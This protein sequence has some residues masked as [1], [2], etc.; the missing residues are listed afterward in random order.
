MKRTSLLWI[1]LVIFAFGCK[2]EKAF[3]PKVIIAGN[4]SNSEAKEIKVY[5]D[6]EIANTKLEEDGSF[7]VSFDADKF[8]NYMLTAGR[9]RLN[10]FLSPGDSLYITGDAAKFGESIVFSGDHE[11]ENA[12]LYEKNNINTKSG[13]S[14][15]M[16]L[17]GL[18]KDAYFKK[19]D[20][21]FG[22]TKSKYE[23]IK[24]E[25]AFDGD[26]VTLE[27]AYYEYEP[28]LYDAQYPMYYA[29]INK[30]SQDS[31]DF[32]QE[33]VKAKFGQINL[34]RED[35][36]DSRSYTSVVD[37]RIGERVS[38]M[39]KADSTLQKDPSGYENARFTAMDDMIE[40]QVV[41]D[42]FLFDYIKSNMQYRGPAHTEASYKKFMEENQSPKLAAK[43]EALKEKWEPIM[44]GKEVPDF[45][46]VN[47]EGEEVNLSDL[48]GNLVYIDIWATWCGPCIAE[49]PHWDKMKEEYKDKSIAFLT[50]SIDDSKDPWEKMVKAK[51]MEGLQWFAK[52]AWK[53]EL[54]QHFMV[55]AIP[56]FILLDKEGKIIDPS[57]DR[58]SGKIRTK[59]D[60]YL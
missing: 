15:Y 50:V 5:L 18:D 4:L 48:K 29:Y 26:F 20:S 46:F 24:T 49:H 7:H 21:I 33:E 57:A 52:D 17:M 35:L 51:N 22:L 41:K 14:N 31:I 16:E 34:G 9:E 54:A 45:S 42:K 19:K 58:P 38:E 60:E 30:V 2:Q 23:S 12:Y 11:A 59:V 55:N 32:P 3:N 43:L 10:L 25:R 44:P 36:L 27:D 8:E 6:E 53:S 13:L 47:I 56:R 39:M 1:A 37:R 28:L 40:N